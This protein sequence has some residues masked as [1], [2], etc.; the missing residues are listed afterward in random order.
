MTSLLKRHPA[1]TAVQ[2]MALFV[3]ERQVA[4]YDGTDQTTDD[5]CPTIHVYRA[6]PFE[7]E[8]LAVAP[9][10]N[11]DAALWAATILGSMVQPDF[12]TMMADAHTTGTMINP[13]TGKQW[14]PGEMQAACDTEG[15]CSVGLLDDCLMFHTVWPDGRAR[16]ETRV[17]TVTKGTGVGG[18]TITW[19]GTAPDSVLDS[20]DTKGNLDGLITDA[21]RQ[22]L[23]PDPML[24]TLAEAVG[25]PLEDRVYRQAMAAL[26][27]LTK[28]GFGCLV[29]TTHPEM[30]ARV[31]AQS[32]E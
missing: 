30:H 13:A 25:I 15:A 10:I 28:A 31:T 26:H 7:L 18:S 2:Q 21:L 12:I 24:N 5:V 9:E 32:E 17:Y 11:R 3:K 14:G 20:A 6:E 19:R 27:H 4:T 16:M 8:I 29:H 1:S 23:Q 22:A